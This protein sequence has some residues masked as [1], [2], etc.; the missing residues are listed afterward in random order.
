[1]VTPKADALW[2]SSWQRPEWVKHAWTR[3]WVCTCFRNESHWLSSALIQQ[4]VAVTR[5]SWG[6][7]P[8]DGMVT[9][10]DPRRIRAK[11]DPG[12]CFLRAGW[13]SC[14][15]TSRGLVVLQL[16]ADAMPPPAEP[17]S[18]LPLF[19]NP[20]ETEDPCPR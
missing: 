16:R 7:P 13:S 5:W 17:R 18:D 11:R 20:N 4:A 2:V 19:P 14:G 12:R 15:R 6:P 9:F 1:L 8:A 3:A 10:I